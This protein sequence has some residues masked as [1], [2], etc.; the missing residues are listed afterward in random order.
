[1][2]INLKKELGK[3]GLGLLY[4]IGLFYLIR[5]LRLGTFGVIMLLSLSSILFNILGYYTKKKPISIKQIIINIIS[6][7]SI[8]LFIKW[9]G[10]WGI[11]GYFSTCFILAMIILFR[12]RKRY[13]QVKHQIESMLWGKPLYQF[14]EA[15]EKPPRIRIGS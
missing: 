7:S 2:K 3:I 8:V 14:K 1:M 12:K 13:I 5:F 10:S 4:V 9:L 11:F 6:I 15:G